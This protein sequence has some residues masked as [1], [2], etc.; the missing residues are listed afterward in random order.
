MTNAME[1]W[2]VNG[3]NAMEN[4]WRTQSIGCK[5]QD[6]K[7]RMKNAMGEWRDK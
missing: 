7:H 3:E 2:R 5:A 4:E 6:A 1:E